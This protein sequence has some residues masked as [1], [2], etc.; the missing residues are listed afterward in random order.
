MSDTKKAALVW[1]FILL[2]GVGAVGALIH[3]PTDWRGA[4][5]AAA[6]DR[7][8]IFHHDKWEKEQAEQMN[9]ILH[10]VPRSIDGNP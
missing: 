7:D 2:G 3:D 4:A 8:R 1:A 5:N 9:R 6:H 10:H